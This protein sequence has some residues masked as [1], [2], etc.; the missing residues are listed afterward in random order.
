MKYILIV[1]GALVLW[2]IYIYNGFVSLKNRAQEAWADIEV[3]LKRRY[4]LI[5]NLVNTVKGYATHESSAFENVTKARSMAMGASGPTK[6]HAKAE[7]MLTGALKSIFAISEAYPDL[8]A[9]TNFLE[10]QR[11]L[12]DTENKIQA[13]RRFYNANVRDLNTKIE[14]FPSNILA[15][16]FHFSKIEF[17]DLAD[18]DAAQNP[19]EVKF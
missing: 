18:N 10:L 17:F 2:A 7:N 11:E 6:E 1:L 4:D 15:G 13:A 3:Q 12:S 8:K 14:S 9:N 19:V 5:P 16:I